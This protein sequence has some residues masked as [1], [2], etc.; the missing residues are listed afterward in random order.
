MNYLTT[1]GGALVTTPRARVGAGDYCEISW[2]LNEV[3]WWLGGWVAN[4]SA[5]KVLGGRQLNERH[6]N[7]SLCPRVCAE[8]EDGLVD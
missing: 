6:I 1:Q 4:C 7:I 2:V 8:L 5:E 3:G